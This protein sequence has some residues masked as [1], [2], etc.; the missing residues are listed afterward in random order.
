[1]RRLPL[2]LTTAML[3]V[4]TAATAQQVAHVTAAGGYDEIRELLVVAIENQGLVVDHAPTWRD[5]RTHRQGSGADPSALR[6]RRGV[7]VLQRELL[8]AR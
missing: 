5:A 4:A 7:A 1:M 3:V 2:L 8:R 6:A